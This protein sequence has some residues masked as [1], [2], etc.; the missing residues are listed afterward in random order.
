MTLQVIERWLSATPAIRIVSGCSLISLAMVMTGG[1]AL[2]VLPDRTAVPAIPAEDIRL[3]K[4][5]LRDYPP[6]QQLTARLA[7]QEKK[8]GAA[9]FSAVAFCQQLNASFVSWK[10]T[11]QGGELVADMP[12]KSVP[13]LFKQLSSFRFQ[14]GAFT[15]AGGDEQ[16]RLTLQLERIDVG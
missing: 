15:L 8:P 5:R 13:V 12:W 9:A 11:D 4:K 10:P 2:L 7:V 6:R 16:L 1:L 3:V 14:S